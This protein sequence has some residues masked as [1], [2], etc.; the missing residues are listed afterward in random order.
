MIRLEKLFMLPAILM[1]M[2]L[3]ACSSSSVWDEVPT[4]ITSF[5]EQYYPG[6]GVKSF[7]QTTD[8]Y[9]VKITNGAS[10]SFDEEYNWTFIDGNGV[11]LPEVLVYNQLPPALFNYLQGIEQQ[12]DVYAMN[13]DKTYYK[14]TMFDTVITYEIATGK[15]SYPDG[16]TIEA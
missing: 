2:F 12:S 5:I 6:S 15:I 16:K 7:S 1:V 8:G 3:S 9:K 10:L 13:R 11:R 14:L 4:P